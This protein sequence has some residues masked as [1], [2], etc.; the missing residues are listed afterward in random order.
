MKVLI[1]TNVLVSAA[2]KDKLPEQVI[3]C[4]ASHP[5][6]EWIASRAILDEYT[7]VLGRSKFSLP[8]E[9]LLRWKRVLESAIVLVDAEMPVEFARDRKDAMFIA[10]AVA[11]GAEFFIT[12]DRDFTEAQR[13]MNTNIVSVTMFHKLFC[14][15]IE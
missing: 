9:I 4:V 12:G 2:L 7:A 8:D 14:E 11:T 5:N 15:E 13:L 1:D 6:L 10:C 3:F